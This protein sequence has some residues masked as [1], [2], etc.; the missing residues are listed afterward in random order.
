MLRC[1]AFH[2]TLGCASQSFSFFLR[3]CGGVN[4]ADR[5]DNISQ[6]ENVR[7][8]DKQS[9][10]PMCPRVVA[11]AVGRV[12]HVCLPDIKVESEASLSLSGPSPE[13]VYREAANDLRC[14][15]HVIEA[16]SLA[17][18]D[19]LVI[20]HPETQAEIQPESNCFVAEPDRGFCQNPH[21]QADGFYE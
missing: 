17:V 8:G 7:F 15:A 21:D 4:S 3:P 13:R 10:V 18:E 9:P 6:R 2:V 16:L 19:G 5:L 11:K 20:G 1:P 12:D 14:L